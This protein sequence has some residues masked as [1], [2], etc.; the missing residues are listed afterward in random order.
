MSDKNW[1]DFVGD[2][3]RR[4]GINVGL[5]LFAA[6]VAVIIFAVLAPPAFDGGAFKCHYPTNTLDGVFAA[7][8]EATPE[9]MDYTEELLHFKAGV[10]NSGYDTC[11]QTCAEKACFLHETRHCTTV[12]SSFATCVRD[13]EHC[14]NATAVLTCLSRSDCEKIG[15]VMLSSK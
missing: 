2:E 10:A 11:F 13:C 3:E 8:I 14:A 5:I 15:F 4:D 12:C 7:Q 1:F 9:R 6:A